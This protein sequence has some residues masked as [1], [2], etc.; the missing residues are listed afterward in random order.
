MNNRVAPAS[1]LPIVTPIAS[2]DF[3][4]RVDGVDLSRPTDEATLAA[5]VAAFDRYAI[6]HF[7]GQQL[8][9]EQQV[10]FPA[11]SARLK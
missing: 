7:P 4:A 9:Q 3:F 1:S 5:I 6:L 11:A 2:R 10:A 8:T